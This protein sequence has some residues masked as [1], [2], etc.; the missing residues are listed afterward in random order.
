M[1]LAFSFKIKKN[2]TKCKSNAFVWIFP[3]ETV[4]KYNKSFVF[5][6]YY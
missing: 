2:K 1:C 3:A 6:F 5:G 4:L